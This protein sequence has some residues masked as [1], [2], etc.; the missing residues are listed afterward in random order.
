MPSIFISYRREESADVSG[1]IGDYLERQFGSRAVFRDVDAILAGSNFVRAIQRALDDARVMLVIIGPHW[2]HM[3]EA[4]GWRRIDLPTDFVHYEIATALRSGKLVVP[5]LV[6]GASL[7]TAA[8]LP[9]DIAALADATPVVVRNDPY[10]ADDMARAVATFRRMVAWQPASIGVLLAGLGGL[11]SLVYIILRAA[12]AI[13]LPH[14][15]GLDYLIFV[16][17]TIALIFSI[18]RAARTRRW[19]WL[20]LMLAAG[21]L[22]LVSY[23]I[24]F[25]LSQ[26]LLYYPFLFVLLVFG[27]FGPRRPYR[28]PE[29]RRP[30]HDGVMATSWIIALGIYFLLALA[31]APP[32]TANLETGVTVAIVLVA[33]LAGDVMGLLRAWQTRSWVWGIPVAILLAFSLGVTSLVLATLFIDLLPDRVL[34]LLVLLVVFVQAIVLA[35]FGWWGPRKLPARPQVPVALHV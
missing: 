11:I 24:P 21:L 8:E 23:L 1:R 2:I 20:T 13:S 19:L 3:R 30:A 29:K 27:L 6:N 35:V 15:R 7:P 28:R 22:V 34:A 33:L 17:P 16:T 31:D 32:P 9:P 18:I 12:H 25:E 14:Y 26:P 10:F 5:I 4:N